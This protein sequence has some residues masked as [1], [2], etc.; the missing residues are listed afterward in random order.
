[1]EK[2]SP[3]E[4]RELLEKNG[5]VVSEQESALVLEFL[6]RLANII[7]AQHLVALDSDNNVEFKSQSASGDNFIKK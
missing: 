4:A 3:R 5:V 1:M 6:R 7:V 2:I